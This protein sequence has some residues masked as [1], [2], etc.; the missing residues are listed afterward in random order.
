MAHP[1]LRDALP[2]LLAEHGVSGAYLAALATVYDELSRTGV[3]PLVPHL[4]ELVGRSVPTVSDHLKQARKDGF[5]TA[6]VA[7]KPGGEPTTKSA[8]VLTKLGLAPT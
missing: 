7:G 5:L 2:R 8:R 3:R 4:A 6:S 1:E